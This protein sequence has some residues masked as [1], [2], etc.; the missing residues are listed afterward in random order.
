MNDRYSPPDLEQAESQEGENTVKDI[1]RKKRRAERDERRNAKKFYEEGKRIKG[2]L[3]FDTPPD[4]S[5]VIVAYTVE[6]W[7]AR[8][9]KAWS[10]IEDTSLISEERKFTVK[11]FPWPVPAQIW[12][13]VT[14]KPMAEKNICGMIVQ[15]MKAKYHGNGPGAEQKE[16]YLENIRKESRRYDFRDKDNVAVNCFSNEEER[17]HG[18]GMAVCVHRFLHVYMKWITCGCAA[19]G[20]ECE[21]LSSLNL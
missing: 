13:S 12:E 16:E 19:K 1:R 8:Y 10:L 6:E 20:I 9:D 15:F 18:R 3:I 2:T 7:V 5:R 14:V 11:K 21:C 4:L 17:E